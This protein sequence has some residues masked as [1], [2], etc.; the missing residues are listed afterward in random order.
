MQKMNNQR[1]YFTIMI[2]AVMSGLLIACSSISDDVDE[3]IANSNKQ[4]DTEANT[5][6]TG[7]YYREP[8]L[9]WGANKSTVKDFMKNYTISEE[10][11]TSLYYRP[12]MAEAYTAYFFTKSK[13]RTSLVCIAES[14]V[15]LDSLKKQH[16]DW[17]YTPLLS[18]EINVAN[19]LS[20]DKVTQVS[21]MRNTDLGCFFIYY[22]DYKWSM[23]YDDS[24]LYEAPF[25][26]WGTERNAVK[27]SMEVHGYT[28]SEDNDDASKKYSLLYN[29]KIKEQYSMYYFNDK[30]QLY[31]VSFAFSQ[32][33][34][35]V[36]NYVNTI[37]SKVTEDKDKGI[38]Y[39]QT[40]DGKSLIA[41][42]EGSNG[43]YV[44]YVR[45]N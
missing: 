1:S 17:G 27:D 25:L 37:S 2:L 20:K 41:V 9:Q 45:N 21:I 19:F 11:D 5:A 8:C 15:S 30:K 39:Y 43:V 34:S 28:L 32:S 23:G 18:A 7:R 35:E 6:R 36:R 42:Q 24:Q 44:I 31:Q 22:I 13:L 12:T 29:G 33:L 14:A 38:Y 26:D 10:K 3:N 4:N 40:K 16:R